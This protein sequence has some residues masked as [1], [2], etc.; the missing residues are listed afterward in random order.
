MRGTILTGDR[1]GGAVL[2]H[3]SL[4]ELPGAQALPA[5]L[6]T[7]K[8][9]RLSARDDHVLPVQDPDP[10]DRAV[11]LIAVHEEL[12]GVFGHPPRVA[13]DGKPANHRS[14]QRHET[15]HNG[16]I[17]C[18]PASCCQTLT[19][20]S[21][22]QDRG[23]ALKRSRTVATSAGERPGHGPDSVTQTSELD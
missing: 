2:I 19:S 16:H 7:E 3:Q 21:P 20:G 5:L 8:A 15:D 17:P 4:P 22:S 9:G 14:L 23:Q 18:D 13:Q 1:T 12:G 6:G 11:L 10:E